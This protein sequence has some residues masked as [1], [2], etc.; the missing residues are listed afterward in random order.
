MSVAFALAHANE[1]NLSVLNVEA[2]IGKFPAIYRGTLLNT[3]LGKVAT[4]NIH[5]LNNT[6]EFSAYIRELLSPSVGRFTL[7]N[8]EE[9][10]ASLGSKLGK[11]LNNN[12]L[13]L[14]SNINIKE[15]IVSARCI[16]NECPVCIS[17]PLFIDDLACLIN[18][19]ELIE[20]PIKEC[21]SISYVN[22]IIHKHN[23][24]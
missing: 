18:V 13:L 8:F 20:S 11:Q 14:I 16:I 5:T 1:A 17:C 22:D 2:F 7:A 24:C 6:V 4:L 10:I 12:L 3:D 21:I 9:V 15:S 23:G 19:S